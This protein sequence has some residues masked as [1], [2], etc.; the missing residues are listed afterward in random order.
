LQILVKQGSRKKIDNG[1]W[2]NEKNFKVGLNVAE[3]NLKFVTTEKQLN[4]FLSNKNGLCIQ[5]F[6]QEFYL[7]VG[8]G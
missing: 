3:L 7:F 2:L 4:I 8:G 1:K 6:N 5:E